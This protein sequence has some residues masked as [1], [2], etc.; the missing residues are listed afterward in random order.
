MICGILVIY[1]SISTNNKMPI[2][3]IIPCTSGTAAFHQDL[4]SNQSHLK[5]MTQMTQ[6]GQVKSCFGRGLILGLIR[7]GSHVK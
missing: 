4:L 6:P 2:G 1:T 5:S 3:N 7:I